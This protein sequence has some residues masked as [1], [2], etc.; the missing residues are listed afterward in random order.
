MHGPHFHFC[1][2]LPTAAEDV[3]ADVVVQSSHKILSA[4]SQAAVLHTKN[5]T[6]DE[7]TVRT[8]LQLIQ[9]TSPHFAIMASI[10][11]ARRQMVLEGKA[12]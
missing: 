12:L 7:L 2:E 3:G 9:T 10:D 11:T 1:D 8:V 5:Q 4:L 6:I